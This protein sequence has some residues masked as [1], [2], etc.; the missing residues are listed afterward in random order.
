MNKFSDYIKIIKLDYNQII[1]D[2]LKIKEVQQD[3]IDYNQKEQLAEGIDAN[4]KEIRTISAV[5]QKQGEN[6]SLYTIKQRQSK[7]LQ[8]DKVDLKEKGAFWKTFSVKV[9][10]DSSEIQANFSKGS[11]DIRDNFDKSYNFLG[12]TDNSKENWTWLSFFKYFADNIRKS[13]NV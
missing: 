8:V 7:G 6:Y 4:E 10:N 13:L 3:M 1:Q 2:T 12:L 11:D 5:E 9:N